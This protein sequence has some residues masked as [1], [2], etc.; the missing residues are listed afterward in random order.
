[1]KKALLIERNSRETNEKKAYVD[2]TLHDGHH[3]K[4]V[5]FLPLIL[6]DE[7]A[8]KGIEIFIG[9][10]EKG[11]GRNLKSIKIFRKIL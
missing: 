7:L 3:S 4:V 6:S 11:G 2:F 1:M 10:R 5:R 9:V 8:E